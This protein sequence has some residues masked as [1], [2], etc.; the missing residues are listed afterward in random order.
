MSDVQNPSAASQVFPGD[1]PSSSPTGSPGSFTVAAPNDGSALGDPPPPRPA[2][3][4]M[5]RAQRLREKKAK[6]PIGR[7]FMLPDLQEEVL[8]KRV[9]LQDLVTMGRLPEHLS[10]PIDDMIADGLRRASGGRN[11][12]RLT[13][14]EAAAQAAER[15]EEETAGIMEYLLES[16]GGSGTLAM[17][18][19]TK[20]RDYTCVAAFVDPKLTLTPGE[21]EGDDALWLEELSER[22]REA[23]FAWCNGQDEEAMAPVIPFR[24]QATEPVDNVEVEP[25]V[26]E[27]TTPT[28]VHSGTEG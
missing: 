19:M 3:R 5:T 25:S 10:K 14:E 28:P 8:L 9:G 15:A 7:P 18:E 23:V 24:D 6:R 17:K 13:P 4:Q 27:G 16:V 12:G 26:P 20:L 11:R 2:P 21:A 1:V 22:D